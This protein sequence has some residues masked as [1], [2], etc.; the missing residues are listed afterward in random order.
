[1][2]ATGF[3]GYLLDLLE[4][5]EGMAYWLK[6]ALNLHRIVRLLV[7]NPLR[8]VLTLVSSSGH[9]AEWKSDC[10]QGHG[11]LWQIWRR[12]VHQWLRRQQRFSFAIRKQGRR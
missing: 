9:R 3:E 11:A 10:H 2:R 4:Y 1:M 12:D 6:G 7:L 5:P 8:P